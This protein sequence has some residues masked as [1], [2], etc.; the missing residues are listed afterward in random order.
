MKTGLAIEDLAS[1]IVRQ[2]EC[3]EDYIVN[4][5]RIAMDCYGRSIYLRILDD[6]GSDR[7][8]PLDV[9]PIAHRQIGTHLSIPAKYYTKMLDED[10]AL[11]VTNVNTWLQRAQSQRMLRVLD[12]SAR[13]FL[14]NRYLR[15]DHF[16]VTQAVIPILGE[17]PDIRFESCQI[18]EN[19]MYIKVVNPAL[20]AEVAPGDVV[21][22]GLMISNSEVGLGSVSVQ[23]LI[24]RV[25]SQTGMFVNDSATKRNH[26]G[27]TNFAEIHFQL[28]ATE[29]FSLD[30]HAFLQT[31][32]RSVRS[33]GNIDR[34][35]S[36][37]EMMRA[38][39]DTPMNTGN[40]PAVVRQT[41]RDFGITDTEQAGVLRHLIASEDM[42][43]Y[44]LANAV[45]RHSQDVDSYDR[46]TD[47]EGIGY[48]IMSMPQNQWNRINQAA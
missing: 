19:R 41:G 28:N 40:I 25:Q 42:T 24:Y 17:L 43:Q 48:S 4:A 2:K 16:P 29:S 37:V 14:S 23:P 7:I 15:M 3:K 46:A 1:E 26:V 9:S 30:D 39:R 20:E 32:Q 34:F 22:A 11:L 47:L 45:T 38:S 12:G 31:I 35:R 5:N 33:A 36:V 13:A 6:N 44:G 8:E 21:Q 18:T 10:P 27:R